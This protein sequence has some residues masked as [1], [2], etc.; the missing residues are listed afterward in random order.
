MP[1]H[2]ICFSERLVHQQTLVAMEPYRG[3]TQCY[4]ALPNAT[5]LYG[6]HQSLLM[7]TLQYIYVY[8]AC[9]CIKSK[10]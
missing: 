8:Y 6:C 3:A 5:G 9:A 4:G 2:H 1:N 7:Y 10:Y